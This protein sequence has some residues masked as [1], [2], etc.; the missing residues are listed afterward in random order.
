[1]SCERY[2]S[3]QGIAAATTTTVTRRAPARPTAGAR[4]EDERHAERDRG[5]EDALALR[6]RRAGEEHRGSG[7]APAAPV[8]QPERE[9]GRDGEEDVEEDVG[10]GRQQ[11]LAEARD[12][13]DEQERR[14]EQPSRRVPVEEP[15]DRGDRSDDEEPELDVE[16]HDVRAAHRVERR[17]VKDRAASGGYV[18]P[19]RS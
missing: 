5:E 9:Q 13:E 10:L 3:R 16:R 6:Q 4:L 7:E 19:A 15:G 8:A 1:M 11:P 2:Q 17:R 18:G 12:D 14:P